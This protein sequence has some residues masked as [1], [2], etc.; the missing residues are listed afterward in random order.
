MT[1][2]CFDFLPNGNRKI[3]DLTKTIKIWEVNNPARFTS[4]F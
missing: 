2:G 1:G 4:I 3:A